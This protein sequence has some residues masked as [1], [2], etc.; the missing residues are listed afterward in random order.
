MP[1]DLMVNKGKDIE[2]VEIGVDGG[3]KWIVGW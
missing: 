1:E 2:K 3:R